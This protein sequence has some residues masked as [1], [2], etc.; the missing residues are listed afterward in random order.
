MSEVESVADRVR[1]LVFHQMRLRPTQS[2]DGNLE[3]MPPF[4]SLDYMELVFL[5]EDEFRVELP[6][7][8]AHSFKKPSDFVKWLE[9]QEGKKADGN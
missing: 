6:D 5:V 3:T 8:I 7:G 2:W 9:A 4:D 1:A